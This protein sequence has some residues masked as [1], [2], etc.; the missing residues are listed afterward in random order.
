M[1]SYGPF[2]R[3]KSRLGFKIWQSMVNQKNKMS[4]ELLDKLGKA[5]EEYKQ[6]AAPRKDEKAQADAA[7]Q[8]TQA[9]T[10]Q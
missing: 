5:I 7:K 9:A 1:P 4:S 6:T 10:A 2:R 3:G 8:A